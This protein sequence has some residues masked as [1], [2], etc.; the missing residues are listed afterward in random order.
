MAEQTACEL[1]PAGLRTA[2]TPCRGIVKGLGGVY[3][4]DSAQGVMAVGVNAEMVAM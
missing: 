2:T 1:T 3:A 4:R